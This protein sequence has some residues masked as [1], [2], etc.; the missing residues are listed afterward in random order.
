M[1]CCHLKRVLTGF[2][3]AGVMH[4][5]RF[6]RAQSAAEQPP[7]LIAFAINGGAATAA[8]SEEFVSLGH[9]AVGRRPS[10]YR[11]SHRAD[12]AGAA[13]L[14]YTESPKLKEWLGASSD[15]CDTPRPSRRVTLFFQVRVTTGAELRVVDGQRALVAASVESNVLRDVICAVVPPRDLERMPNPGRRDGH[16]D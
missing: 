10:E 7:V 3:V 5:T 12:F 6:A 9:T 4:A 8:T 14:P 16:R 11:V 15:A 2:L 13:W 1:G